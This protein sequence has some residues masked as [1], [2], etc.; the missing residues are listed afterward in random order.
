MIER[1]CAARGDAHCVW[2]VRWKNPPL[3]ARFWAPA[4]AGL[5]GSAVVVLALGAGSAVAWPLVGALVL[6]P[7]SSESRSAT[8]SSSARGG[9]SSSACGT[10]RRDEILYSSGQLEGKF[11]DLETKIEQLSLL[12]DLAAAV[13]ATLDVE[14]IYAQTLQRLVHGMGYQAAYLFLV[15]P[16]RRVV[17]GHRMA[18]D[19]AAGARFEEVEFRLDDPRSAT[20]R[21]ATS[22]RPIV[23]GGRRDARRSHS[24]SPR[25]GASGCVRC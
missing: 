20:A 5:A 12:I 23:V 11:R 10:S 21:V 18:G 17:R 22:G 24:T 13:N 19:V 25:S 4:A 7:A 6:F 9:G 3:G 8:G 1:A 16:A 14:T 15:D 2:D